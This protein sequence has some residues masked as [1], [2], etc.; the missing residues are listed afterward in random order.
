[1]H[2]QAFVEG[3][4]PIDSEPPNKNVLWIYVPDF[5]AQGRMQDIKN[6]TTPLTTNNTGFF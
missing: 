1:M 3:S 4:K 5:S 6:I 2:L